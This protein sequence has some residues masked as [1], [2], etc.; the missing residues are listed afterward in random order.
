MKKLQFDE[1]LAAI[2]RGD[3]N[4]A[5]ELVRTYEPFIRRIIR[6]RLTDERLRRIFDSMDIC[7]SIMANF[8]ARAAAGQF[9]LQTPEQLRNLLVTM[10]INKLRSKARMERKYAGSI[11]EN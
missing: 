10:A 9:N 6:M 2:R 11:P 8:F 3:Q 1:F 4:A 5:E 7:Q